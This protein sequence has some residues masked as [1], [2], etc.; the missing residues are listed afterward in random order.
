M[1]GVLSCLVELSARSLEEKLELLTVLFDL[2]LELQLN[3]VPELLISLLQFSLLHEF[4]NPDP[5]SFHASRELIHFD[6]FHGRIACIELNELLLDC[7]ADGQLD[8]FLYP[9]IVELETISKL[10]DELVVLAAI[11]PVVEFVLECLR[12]HEQILTALSVIICLFR[13]LYRF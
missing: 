2:C 6:L 5:S 10:A 13:F 7:F 9:L 12:F 11:Q 3:H 4:L 8:F 1:L